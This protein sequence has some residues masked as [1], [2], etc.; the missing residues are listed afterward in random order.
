MVPK[1]FDEKVQGIFCIGGRTEIGAK[2]REEWKEMNQ[3]QES[4]NDKKG[5]LCGN[6]DSSQ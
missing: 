4:T 2:I 1:I 5:N 3:K 6:E